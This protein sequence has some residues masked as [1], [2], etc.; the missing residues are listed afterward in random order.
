M[1]SSSLF[2]ISMQQVDKNATIKVIN[3]IHRNFDSN[4]LFRIH[5]FMIPDLHDSS[6]F[7]RYPRLISGTGFPVNSS[8]FNNQFHVC[9]QFPG[10]PPAAV[11]S[12]GVGVGVGGWGGWG[13]GGW[14]VGVGGG[15]GGGWGGVHGEVSRADMPTS[16]CQEQTPLLYCVRFRYTEVSIKMVYGSNIT[17]NTMYYTL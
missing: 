13:G 12:R 5:T 9:G 14:G 15:G 16:L 10:I 6:P 11:K 4:S 8:Q 17:I 3:N 1:L 7:A 2:K